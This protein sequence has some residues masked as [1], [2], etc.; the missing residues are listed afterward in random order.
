MPNISN[1]EVYGLERV[2]RTAK[3][4]KAVNVDNLDSELTTGIQGCLSC[5]T[6]EGHDNA[7]KGVIVQFDLTASQNFWMQGERYHWF[8]I[9]SSQSKMHK[10]TKFSLKEQCNKYVDPR[11][12][13]IVQA[14]I[15]EY[16]RL[17]T[18]DMSSGKSAERKKIMD[19]LYL[20]ILYNIPCG[21]E[22]TAG[23]TTNYQQ[24]KTMYKQ[25]RHHRLPEWQMV[26]DW[27]E[28]LPRFM[29]LTQ[30]SK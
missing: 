27:I 24:L 9:V 7:L 26:C 16:N 19:E 23:M 4:P 21:F 5:A 25:R 15:D 12:I 18:L 6:G 29:E 22:L 11:I 13:D 14:K 17:V 3:Y 10:I 28:T 20:E 8:D 2:I 1:V 30:R